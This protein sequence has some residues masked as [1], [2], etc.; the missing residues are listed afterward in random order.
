MSTLQHMETEKFQTI[1]KIPV[2]DHVLSDEA[3]GLTDGFKLEPV[4][5][6]KVIKL[7][8]D[9]FSSRLY[10]RH[11]YALQ[12]IV[13]H[14][15]QGFLLKDLV[16]IINILNICCNRLIEIPIYEEPMKHLLIICSLPFLKEKT[17][18]E[19]FY[20]ELAVESVCQ[21]GYLL[22][23][24]CP[25][26]QAQICATLWS[27]YS[28]NHPTQHVFKH[29]PCTVQFLRKIIEQ[30]DVAV[31]LVKAIQLVENDR[32][33]KL[34]VLETLQK[35]SRHSAMCCDQMLS[36]N[37]AYTLCSQLLDPD[38][39]GQLL[40]RS[41]EIMWNLMENTT[42]LMLISEQ[43]NNLECICQLQNA[44]MYQLTQGYSNYDSQLR[45]DILVIINLVAANTQKAPFVE[46]GLVRHLVLFATFPEVKSHSILL[47]HLQ[48]TAC[49]EDF[50]MKK[51]L[52]MTLC[53]LSKYPSVLPI[54]TEGRLLLALFS[55]VRN[56]QSTAPRR[57]WSVA[58]YE[59][60]QL[61]A[62]SCLCILCPL[63]LE[64]FMA[65]QGSTRL[66]LLL[67]WC[68]QKDDFKGHG[69]SFY[70]DNS[71]GT[72]NAQKRLCLRLLFSVVAT[73]NELIIKD[74]VDQGAMNL[75]ISILSSS[76]FCTAK[77]CIIENEMKS[78]MLLILSHLC[79]GNAHHKELF[80]TSGVDMLTHF[81]KTDSKVI[82]SGQGFHSLL[83]ATVD[84]VW[85]SVIG[86]TLSEN[87]FLENEGC[88]LLLDLLEI[89][90]QDM[91]QNVL[92]CL[93]DLCCENPQT[94]K[95]ILTWKG[96][97]ENVSAPHF[98]CKMWR[99]EERQMGVRRQP[100]GAIADPDYPLM[101]CLQMESGFYPQSACCASQA[102]VDVVENMRGKIYCF[103]CKL[104]FDDLPGLQMIDHITL[105][106][107][108]K[109]L[110]FKSGEV[111]IEI[112]KE[113]ELEN[114]EPLKDD[115]AVCDALLQRVKE[116]CQLN[117]QFQLK[118]IESQKNMDAL[119]EQELYAEIRENN[120]QKEMNQNSWA[121]FVSRT[122]SYNLL[123]AAKLRQDLSI[124]LS[125]LQ[126]IY[127]NEKFFHNITMPKL[128]TTVFS[129]FHVQIEKITP[130]HMQHQI[131]ENGEE[132]EQ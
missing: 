20:A 14:Y 23:A 109:Y 112:V 54:L 67:E 94:V 10:E 24:P 110:T 104:G 44:F 98:F 83:L 29:E 129:G 69:N 12:K 63:L 3:A 18:D 6:R 93:L 77:N 80:G 116:C 25:G 58:E 114:V 88:F 36:E 64:D 15:H 89:C 85:C 82:N 97:K 50:E 26:I 113:L 130:L 7:L 53:S 42:N 19:I 126:K 37:I 2:I 57:E 100:S 22:R 21:I 81:L 92:G 45:N 115:K 66:L 16:H 120:R 52:Y 70:G 30:S 91:Q 105:V 73:K 32:N 41:V 31:T 40:F 128:G 78:T 108:E 132:K 90:S 125:R 61:H 34:L 11:V 46:S 103:F 62:L 27:L 124:D 101:G 102:I 118:L 35:L 47:K 86:C 123:K 99:E 5:L 28:E 117:M 4:N 51:L 1:K 71:R 87:Y 74:L 33:N 60:L 8:K 68:T 13:R 72:K 106:I 75:I 84:C 59:E 48:I 56:N 119:D 131:K 111:W 121:E 96:S 55:F 95:H 122:S 79:E 17:S 38:P 39:T 43:L 65:C 107:I 76:L 9:T 49:H 127:R